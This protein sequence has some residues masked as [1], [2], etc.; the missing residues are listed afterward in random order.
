MLSQLRETHRSRCAAP[1]HRSFT[2][3]GFS[4]S[5]VGKYHYHPDCHRRIGSSPIVTTG[6]LARPVTGGLGVPAEVAIIRNNVL[7]ACVFSCQSSRRGAAPFGSGEE[8]LHL[9]RLGEAIFQPSGQ[10]FLKKFFDGAFGAQKKPLADDD[11]STKGLL[12]CIL[13][14]LLPTEEHFSNLLYIR[15]FVR[16]QEDMGASEHG[17]DSACVF[18][19]MSLLIRNPKKAN[20]LP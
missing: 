1:C 14:S 16:P 2:S 5:P 13:F 20:P 3:A 4:A 12:I 6:F 15:P 11:S 18:F 19:F 10:I 17:F 9:F 7:C 8:P